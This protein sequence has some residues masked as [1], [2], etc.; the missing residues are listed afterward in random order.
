MNIEKLDEAIA[1]IE[2]HP[3]EHDQSYWFQKK[4]CGTAMCLAG[5]IAWLDGWR[6]VWAG[7]P[8]DEDHEASTVER[9]G[10]RA[11]V[12]ECARTIL[13]PRSSGEHNA[14]A[15][16]FGANTTLAEIKQFRDRI[17]AGEL[18]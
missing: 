2:E 14:V 17:V 5:T 16:M 18:R 6:P 11:D 9:G 13:A 10:V 3:E 15:N 1:Y 12:Q 4:D 7:H 8:E